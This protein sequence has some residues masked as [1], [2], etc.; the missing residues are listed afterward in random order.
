MTP[1][2]PKAAKQRTGP[3]CS[4]NGILGMSNA[5]IAR[6]P[7]P[8]AAKARLTKSVKKPFVLW[9]DAFGAAW[10][11][12]DVDGLRF[13]RKTP[14]DQFGSYH[15]LPLATMRALLNRHDTRLACT[16]PAKQPKR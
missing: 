3:A 8:K 2:H 9:D 13:Y 7:K 5:E 14:N 6:S 15:L 1:T 10:F 4:E 12:V 11:H 16:R